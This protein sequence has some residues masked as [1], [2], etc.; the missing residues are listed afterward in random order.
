MAARRSYQTKHSFKLIPFI[1]AGIFAIAGIMLL[2]T[3]TTAQTG[4]K[5]L[6]SIAMSVV[7]GDPTPSPISGCFVIDFLTSYYC[8]NDSYRYTSYR[9]LN[10][11]HATGGPTECKTVSTWYEYAKAD[12]AKPTSCVTYPT[13]SPVPSPPVYTPPPATPTPYPTP[14]P[15]TPPPKTPPP[16]TPTPTPRSTTR[17]SASVTPKPTPTPTPCPWWKF[18]S[19]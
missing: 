18:G 13:A 4:Q 11:E 12:C 14:P 16:A 19:C 2:R 3:V 17:P 15:F 9:C 7:N 6:S 10:G 8:G 5:V 1:G